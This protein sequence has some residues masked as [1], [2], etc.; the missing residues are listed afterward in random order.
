MLTITF[1]RSHTIDIETRLFGFHFA[2]E[3]VYSPQVHEKICWK[4]ALEKHV[5]GHHY[6]QFF[7]Q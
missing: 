4:L 3:I 5:S 6:T 1:T 2:C 7:L